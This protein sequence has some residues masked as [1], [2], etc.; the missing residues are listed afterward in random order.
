MQDQQEIVS[1][2]LSDPDSKLYQ[3]KVKMEQVKTEL[4]KFGLSQNQAKVFIYLGKY[5]PKTAR[6]YQ[7]RLNYP[8]L[9]RIS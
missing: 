7:K 4:L 9:R 3:Y 5:G 1:P 2:L 8:E 6:R